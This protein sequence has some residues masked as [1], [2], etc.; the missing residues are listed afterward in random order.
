MSAAPFD[1][2]ERRTEH[3]TTRDGESLATD[4]YLPRG[5]GPFPVLLERTPYGRRGTNHAD[6]SKASQS[7]LCKAE[8]ARLFTAAGFGY[9]IQDCRGRFDSSGVFEKY[10]HA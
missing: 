7:P 3:V 4:V 9:V 2:V 10:I 6:Y 1:Q 5:D 8:V